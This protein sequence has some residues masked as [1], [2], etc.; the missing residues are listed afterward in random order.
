[1]AEAEAE[2]L[3]WGWGGGGRYWSHCPRAHSCFPTT[4]ELHTVL[5]LVE[6]LTSQQMTRSNGP[7]FRI[8]WPCRVPTI[9]EQ[10]ASQLGCLWSSQLQR[11]GCCHLAGL[12]EALQ[13]LYPL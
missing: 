9:L 10:P 13:R 6:E 3:R 11:A 7:V 4:L 12:D 5:L 8:C 1:M 2:L